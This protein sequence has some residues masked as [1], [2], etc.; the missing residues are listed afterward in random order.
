MAD[1]GALIEASGCED[2]ILIGHDWG[3]ILAWYFAMRLSHPL[4]RLV[5]MNVPHP[6]PFEAVFKTAKQ[7]RKSFYGAVFQIPWLPEMLLRAGDYRAIEQAFL[8]SAANP[9]MFPPE[10]IDVY[11]KAAAQ[12]G[13]LTAMLNYYRALIRGGGAERQRQLGYPTIEVPTLMLWGE[14][15]VALSIEGTYGTEDYVRDLTLRTL[16][17]VSHWVQQDDPET[18]NAM[19]RSWLC[20]EAVPEVGD[21]RASA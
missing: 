16:P 9:S 21:V 4:A 2:V 8:G 3:A 12:P 13:A 11:R 5:I 19:L 20:G 6:G 17:G 10:V 14:N 1:V 15:D 7:R 18:V